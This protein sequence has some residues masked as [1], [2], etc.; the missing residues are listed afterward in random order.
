MA[1]AE[2]EVEMLDEEVSETGRP[3][4]CKTIHVK[5]FLGKLDKFDRTKD[6]EISYATEFIDHFR[7]C[8]GLCPI[9]VVK[10]YNFSVLSKIDVG[11]N[12]SWGFKKQNYWKRK[13]LWKK[14]AKNMQ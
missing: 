11:H 6:V 10:C 9:H 2:E 13:G 4:N 8:L 3:L 7:N 12:P 1:A 5:T 14:T